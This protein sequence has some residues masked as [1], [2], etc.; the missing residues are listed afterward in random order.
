MQGALAK[1]MCSAS[2]PKNNG[3]AKNGCAKNLAFVV[4]S[5]HADGKGLCK[6]NICFLH[7]NRKFWSVLERGDS[8]KAKERACWGSNPGLWVTSQR[9]KATQGA[10]QNFL[11]R[12]RHRVP[13][14]ALVCRLKPPSK[15]HKK[16]RVALKKNTGVCVCVCVCVCACACAIV[17]ERVCVVHSRV[18]CSPLRNGS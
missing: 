11:C 4:Q 12:A 15:R 1:K 9:N 6:G 13:R 16:R 5:A 8:K 7:P 18:E 10:P 17:F 14:D 2:L 3:C